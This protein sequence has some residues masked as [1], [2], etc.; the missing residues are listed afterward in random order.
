MV[1]ARISVSVTPL[2]VAPDALPGPHTALSVPKSPGPGP[3]AVVTVAAAAGAVVDGALELWLLHAA[4]I[5][6]NDTPT[7]AVEFRKRFT[8]PPEPHRKHLPGAGPWRDIRNAEPV[9]G[10]VN[11]A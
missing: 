1:A 6:A 4:P 8:I 10:T 7:T 5:N 3:A 11:G 2:S 9:T